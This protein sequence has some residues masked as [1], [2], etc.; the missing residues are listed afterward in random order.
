MIKWFLAFFHLSDK[1]ICEMSVGKGM[2][3][4]YHDYPDSTESR[5]NH[6][7]TQICKRCGKSFYL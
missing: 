4:D 1:A 2:W 5:P 6:F 7:T 3:D